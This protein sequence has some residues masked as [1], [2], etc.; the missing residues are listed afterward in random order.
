MAKENT[1][2]DVENVLPATPIKK[3]RQRKGKQTSVS[4]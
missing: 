4:E 2:S 1:D 3:K